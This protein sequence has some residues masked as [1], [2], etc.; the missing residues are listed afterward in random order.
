MELVISK[1]RHTPHEDSTICI[2][3]LTGVFSKNQPNNLLIM[4]ITVLLIMALYIGT[5]KKLKRATT[6]EINQINQAHQN[7]KKSCER[8][9][10]S[11]DDGEKH[12][13]FVKY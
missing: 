5:I 11:T 9:R 8:L 2:L 4:L 3:L 6:P 12:G 10:K 13:K 7:R 1:R